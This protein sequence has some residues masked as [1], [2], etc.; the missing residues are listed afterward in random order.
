MPNPIRPDNCTHSR[1]QAVALVELLVV[2]VV[3][4]I[5]GS[6]MMVSTASA[7][8]AGD[9]AAV[10]ATALAYHRAI[11]EYARQHGGSKPVIS[12][13]Q[14]PIPVQGPVARHGSDETI[15]YLRRVPEAVQDGRVAIGTGEAPSKSAF[16]QVLNV[17]STRVVL[18]AWS[19]GRVVC[20]LGIEEKPSC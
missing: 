6:M 10:R 5:I 12:T 9:R 16:V 20:E 15:R 8:R 18:R 11:M 3:L 2:M 4:G 19:N 14:W 13:A 1:E 7:R 17:D